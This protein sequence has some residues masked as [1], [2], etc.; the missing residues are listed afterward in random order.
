M[1][2][3]NRLV[4]TVQNI[5]ILLVQF[6]YMEQMYQRYMDRHGLMVVQPAVPAAVSATYQR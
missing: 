1:T 3:G 6:G 2:Q 4:A 5:A